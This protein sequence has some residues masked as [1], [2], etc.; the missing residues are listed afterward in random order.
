MMQETLDLFL[1][2]C[3]EAP[4]WCYGYMIASIPLVYFVLSLY[5]IDVSDCNINGQYVSCRMV[6]VGHVVGRFQI[7][8]SNLLII[9][10]HD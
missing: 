4:K 5:P 10:V 6:L 7:D 9:A 8:L 3:W 2:C 1:A